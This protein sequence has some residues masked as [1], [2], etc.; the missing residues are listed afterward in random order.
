M[1]VL[2]LIFIANLLL[3]NEMIDTKEYVAFSFLLF[4]VLILIVINKR[5]VQNRNQKL[6]HTQNKKLAKLNLIS[7]KNR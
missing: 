6:I 7:F 4:L 2:F 1:R 3:A 5:P